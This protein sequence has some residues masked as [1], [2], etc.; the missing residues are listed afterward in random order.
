MGTRDSAR[1]LTAVLTHVV[2]EVAYLLQTEIRLARAEISEKLSRAA[3]GGAMLGIAA[4]LSLCGLFVLL[5]GAV[6]WLEIAGVPDQWGM[7]IVG[8]AALLIAIVLALVGARNLKGSAL[9]P[10][11]TIEQ[12]RADFSIAKEHV[13]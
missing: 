3:N 4:I 6:R 8:G 12:V 11:R 13:Q 1:P 9:K 2:S 10:E 5:L 7:L